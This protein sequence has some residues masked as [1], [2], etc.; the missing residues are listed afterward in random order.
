M[1]KVHLQG[2][3]LTVTKSMRNRSEKTLKKLFKRYPPIKHQ[4]TV[5]SSPDGVDVK[6]NYQDNLTSKTV[7][8]RVKD[9]YIGLVKLREVL[10]SRL[11][12]EHK[13]SLHKKRRSGRLHDPIVEQEQDDGVWV[14]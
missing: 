9:F 4:I 12:K 7:S 10:I 6:I 13:A 11:E 5:N 1:S 8:V 3:N 14:S 2:V